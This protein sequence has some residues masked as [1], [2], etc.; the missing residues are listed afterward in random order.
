LLVAYGWRVL[1]FGTKGSLGWHGN[2]MLIRGD[3]ALRETAA[4]SLPGL[5]PRGAIRAAFDTALGPL[6]VVGL[7]LGL[8]RRFRL[9]Q[10]RSVSR[11]LRD[12]PQMPTL[13]AGD[14][15]EW[16]P[17]SA[18][19]TATPGLRFCDSNHSFPAPRPI[20]ALDRFALGPGLLAKSTG[21]WSKRPA[22]IASDH[23]PVWID[24]QAERG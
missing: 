9:L 4:I 18:L 12:L 8:L 23:L 11:G 22:Q 21:V 13:L 20:A 24:L 19:D 10:L 6:R 17:V 15:N 5:E 1:P 3:V 2:A 16:G 14:F 7:P